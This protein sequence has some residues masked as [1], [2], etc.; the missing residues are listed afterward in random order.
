MWPRHYSALVSYGEQ[1]GHCNPPAD[2]VYECEL[3]GLGGGVEEDGVVTSYHYKGKL[4]VWVQNQR[5]FRR[6]PSGKRKLSP[7]REAL[8]QHLVDQGEWTMMMSMSMSMSTSMMMSM[9]MSMM[10]SM[11]MMSMSMSMMMVMIMSMMM[12]DDAALELHN[13]LLVG[14]FRW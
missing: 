8:L 7:D 12:H 3:P 9:S 1:H 6:L 14:L 13:M 5:S 11:S 10:I 4:G 2:T